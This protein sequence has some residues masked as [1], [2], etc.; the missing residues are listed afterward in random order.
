MRCFFRIGARRE[1]N[2]AWL[3]S[4]SE[5]ETTSDFASHLPFATAPPTVAGSSGA[6]RPTG[7]GQICLS[8]FCAGG[9]ILRHRRLGRF[10]AVANVVAYRRLPPALRRVRPVRR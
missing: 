4:Y 9:K 5:G 3:A 10:F 6:I 8:V 2:G 1:T 7:P